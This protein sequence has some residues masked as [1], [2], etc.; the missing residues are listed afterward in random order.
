MGTCDGLGGRMADIGSAV[1]VRLLPCEKG[2][3]QQLGMSQ[4]V[5]AVIEAVV[6]AFLPSP[7]LGPVLVQ[8]DTLPHLPEGT[9]YHCLKRYYLNAQYRRFTYRRCASSLENG[10]CLL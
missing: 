6:F 2:I 3:N 1:L 4:Y 7:F 8:C 5:V 9:S 10:R